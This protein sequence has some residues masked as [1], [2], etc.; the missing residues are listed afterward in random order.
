MDLEESC[1]PG[2]RH[3]HSPGSVWMMALRSGEHRLRRAEFESV[4]LA[5]QSR[6]S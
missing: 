1:G 5:L 2:I 3:A 4:Y 6:A